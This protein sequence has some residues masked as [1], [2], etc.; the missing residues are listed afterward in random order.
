MMPLVLASDLVVTVEVPKLQ[1]TVPSSCVDLKEYIWQHYQQ[2]I[3]KN[4]RVSKD[5]EIKKE[6]EEEEEEEVSN[7]MQQPDTSAEH[8]LQAANQRLA[9]ANRLLRR[10]SAAQLQHF[11]CMSHEIRTPLNCIVGL[12][13]LLLHQQP[14]KQWTA[15]HTE[16]VQMIATSGDLLLTVVNDV[17]DY[18]KLG[19]YTVVLCCLLLSFYNL[20]HTLISYTIRVG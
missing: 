8:R 16:S 15:H 7:G 14:Q 12:S 3:Q 1:L 2:E 10:A 9:H 11:A 19:N 13:S 5:E 17:L 6:E 18:S 20:S 4:L